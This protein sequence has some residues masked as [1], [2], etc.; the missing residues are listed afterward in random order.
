MQYARQHL[1]QWRKLAETEWWSKN[2]TGETGVI[3]IARLLPGNSTDSYTGKLVRVD[4]PPKI[5]RTIPTRSDRNRFLYELAISR[6]HAVG[7]NGM[8]QMHKLRP[9][10]NK[11]EVKSTVLFW[12][13][14]FGSRVLLT[15]KETSSLT[16][17]HHVQI[18]Q[19][20]PQAIWE[21]QRREE[22][23]TCLGL[24]HRFARWQR[25]LIQF[26]RKFYLNFNLITS[27]KNTNARIVAFLGR[28]FILLLKWFVFLWF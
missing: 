16:V 14:R 7:I 18:E 26:T 11:D 28:C 1:Q 21:G 27:H 6:A 10:R 5:L 8:Q 25:P 13:G 12:S 4:N 20:I 9:S 19:K 24:C 23:Q 2:I 17:F 3:R 15:K 22:R